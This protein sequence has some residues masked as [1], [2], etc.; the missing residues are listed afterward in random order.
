[1]E[2]PR[3]HHKQL[4]EANSIVRYFSN[5][6]SKPWGKTGEE[7]LKDYALIEF[8]ESVLSSALEKSAE[9]ALTLAESVIEKAGLGTEPPSPAEIIIFSTIYDI[10]STAKVDTHP[11]LSAWFTNVVKTSWAKAGIEKVAV[12]TSI[13][14]IKKSKGSAAP[15]E[16]T[17]P[18]KMEKKLREGI[19]MKV[20][21][22]GEKMLVGPAVTLRNSVSA[23]M[24]AAFPYPVKRTSSS[25]LPCHM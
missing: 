8:E 24:F 2:S 19:Q 13:K 21:K 25:P 18:R 22:E 15:A 16:E 7:A 5:I 14:P 12:S 11:A 9:E 1:L 4:I 17:A 23:N 3:D 20:P 10:A 6:G